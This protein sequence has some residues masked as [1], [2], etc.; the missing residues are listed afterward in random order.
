MKQQKHNDTLITMQDNPSENNKDYETKLTSRSKHY[1]SCDHFG[2]Q[3]NSDA[4]QQHSHT[5]EP[6][7]Q[8]S[9]TRKS[10]L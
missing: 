10:N 9:P 3:I 7:Q 6:L 4:F 2:N 5:D 8:I 1:Y